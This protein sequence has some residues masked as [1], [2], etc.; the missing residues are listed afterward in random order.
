[1]PQ[2]R[3]THDSRWEIRLRARAGGRWA[4]AAAGDSQCDSESDAGRPPPPA[5]LNVTPSPSLE[6]PWRPAVGLSLLVTVLVTIC[7]SLAKP[8]GSGS[9][10]QAEPEARPPGGP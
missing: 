2:D 6:S 7:Q 9:E 3:D 10:A 1:M 4:A 5:I 8:G